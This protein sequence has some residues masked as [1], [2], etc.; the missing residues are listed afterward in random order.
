MHITRTRRDPGQ[1]AYKPASAVLL[2][3]VGKLVASLLL[4][5]RE[6][7]HLLRSEER[8][9]LALTATNGYERDDD[10]ARTAAR[11]QEKTSVLY[12]ADARNQ[13]QENGR[14][15]HDDELERQP[16]LNCEPESSVPRRR[17]SEV[18]NGD[19]DAARAADSQRQAV[20]KDPDE[21]GYAYTMG[22]PPISFSRIASRMWRETF[23]PDWLK[24]SVPAFLFT[25]QSNLAY[26]ASSNLSVPVFQITYQLKVGGVGFRRSSH[27]WP[28]S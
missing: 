19:I 25:G 20:H 27:R 22:Q 5:F 17:G 3:E 1:P 6:V 13:P 11:R 15:H 7:K 4:S 23:G 24:L 8:E 12:D 2:T 21:V 9:S 14:G 18:R 28:T 16:G 26:Y 10:D